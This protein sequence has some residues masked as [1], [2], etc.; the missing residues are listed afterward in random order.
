MLWLDNWQRR[1]R[2]L[3]L[4]FHPPE[5]LR[6]RDRRLVLNGEFLVYCGDRRVLC[7]SKNISAGGMLVDRVLPFDRDDRL[8][9]QATGF[10]RALGARIIRVEEDATALIFDNPRDA[11]TLIGW[12]CGEQ[13]AKSREPPPPGWADRA[14]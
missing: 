7:R 3:P 9:V 11:L 12:L 6:R 4:L 8:E 10:H 5:N 14:S 2:Q 13:H 1:L